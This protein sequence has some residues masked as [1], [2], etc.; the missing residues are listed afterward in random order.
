MVFTSYCTDSAICSEKKRNVEQREQQRVEV[1]SA[2]CYQDTSR[3]VSRVLICLRVCECDASEATQSAPPQGVWDVVPKAMCALPYLAALQP[4][5]SAIWTR[6]ANVW[7]LGPR[8]LG[9]HP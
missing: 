5:E 2:P 7:D 4:Y 8:A 1:K 6:V 3:C 9:T